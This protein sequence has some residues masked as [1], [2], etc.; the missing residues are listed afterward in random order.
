MMLW[1][2]VA[3]VLGGFVFPLL[4]CSSAA[5]LA[6]FPSGQHAVGE[7]G[8][9]FSNPLENLLVL[10]YTVDDSAPGSAKLTA[11]TWWCLP[12]DRVSVTE[13]GATRL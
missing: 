12:Y 5:D 6:P 10:G 2:A 3:V 4:A 9:L 1:A 8:Q 7:A 11:R 13:Q